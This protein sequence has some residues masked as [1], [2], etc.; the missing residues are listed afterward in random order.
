VE[1]AQV[2]HN[3]MERDNKPINTKKVRASCKSQYISLAREAN[4]FLK[5]FVK[6]ARE[7]KVLDFSEQNVY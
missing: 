4:D 3:L 2:K 6:L 5:T 7:I 1:T